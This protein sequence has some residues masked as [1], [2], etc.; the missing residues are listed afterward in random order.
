MNTEKFVRP[1]KFW[2]LFKIGFS[3]LRRHLWLLVAINIL[4]AVIIFAGAFLPAGSLLGAMLTL[5][6][7]IFQYFAIAM[8]LLLA[9]NMALGRTVNLRNAWNQARSG[10][11]FRRLLAASF[12]LIVL[13]VILLIVAQINSVIE[14][15]VYV[16]AIVLLCALFMMSCIAILEKRSGFHTVQRAVLFTFRNFW[17]IAFSLLVMFIIVGIVPTVVLAPIIAFD[18]PI[19]ILL[20]LLLFLFVTA[21][22][23]AFQNLTVVLLYYE[24]RARKENYN[25]EILAQDMGY[26]ASIEMMSA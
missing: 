22:M 23:M 21:L 13:A 5:I 14:L 24:I 7:Y 18:N 1:M 6:A 15:L 11:L 26:Q 2:E 9:S 10:A 20:L 19:I 17:R 16:F 4:P 3:L 12:W 25:E 8:T